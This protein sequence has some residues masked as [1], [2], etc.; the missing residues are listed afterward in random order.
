LG[1]GVRSQQ[2][3]ASPR[4][5]QSFVVVR[6]CNARWA[7]LRAGEKPA[8]TRAFA[9]PRG[10]VGLGQGGSRLVWSG[11][12]AVGFGQLQPN[13]SSWAPP[14]VAPPFRLPFPPRPPPPLYTPSHWSPS[15]PTVPRAL[16]PTGCNVEQVLGFGRFLRLREADAVEMGRSPPRW[17]K[18]DGVAWAR[19]RQGRGL[20][21]AEATA[22]ARHEAMILKR[23]SLCQVGCGLRKWGNRGEQADKYGRRMAGGRRRRERSNTRG[24]VRRGTV[25]ISTVC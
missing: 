17:P 4:P 25:R 6:W 20:A 11:P 21:V 18:V 14:A 16:P 1:K 5:S 24:R 13:R 9:Q 2:C 12:R 23:R 15:T 19:W 22:V 7:T 10:R 3:P 8:T